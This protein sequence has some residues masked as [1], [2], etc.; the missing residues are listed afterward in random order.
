MLYRRGFRG[1]V[2]NVKVIPGEEVVQ[3]HFLLVSDF[4][5]RIPPHKKRK[6]VPRLRSWKLRDPAVVSR[7]CEVFR[8]KVAATVRSKEDSPV[9][10]AWSE[11]KPPLL[12]AT[13]ETCGFSS[14]NQ[15][16]RQTWW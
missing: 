6:F 1:K 12:E 13:P 7:F 11:L 4:S 16:R 15:C 10:A 2:T 3:Q 5:V 9:E 14:G 8:T